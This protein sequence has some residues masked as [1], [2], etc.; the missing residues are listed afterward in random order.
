MMLGFGEAINKKIK[1]KFV[2]GGILIIYNLLETKGK[3]NK[4]NFLP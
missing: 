4:K 2:F 3:I 1:A